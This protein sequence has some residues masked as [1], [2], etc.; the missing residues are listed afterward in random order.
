MLAK[1]TSAIMMNSPLGNTTSLPFLSARLFPRVS[2]QILPFGD[3]GG[4][5]IN[6]ILIPGAKR[7]NADVGVHHL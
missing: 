4:D 7:P 1:T 6:S 3:A 5:Y 2:R